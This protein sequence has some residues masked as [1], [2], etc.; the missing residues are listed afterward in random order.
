MLRYWVVGGEY[1][2]TRFERIAG[3]GPEERIGPFESYDDANAAWQARAWAT[4]DNAHAR[5]RIEEDGTDLG[6]WV[7][8]GRY[9]DTQF[10]APAE[11][12]GERWFG[13]FASYEAAKAEW[14]RLAWQTVD[15]A[16]VRYR[17]ER[18]A[19]QPEQRS[20]RAGGKP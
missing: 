8:G 11:P 15:D 20:R 19:G 4:V 17:I 10:R 16:L 2:D 7:V 18:R 3:G 6:Y 12:I 5:Y 14:A 9:Q 13:P 1:A